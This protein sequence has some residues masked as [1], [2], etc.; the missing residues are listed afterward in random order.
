MNEINE[1]TWHIQD[2]GTEIDCSPLLPVKYVLGGRWYT[3][4]SR[5][6][7]T[8]NPIILTSDLVTDWNYE[9]IPNL[10]ETGIYNPESINKMR[11]MIFGQNAGRIAA[12]I[13]Y[14]T[15]A[16][17]NPSHQGFKFD[18]LLASPIM[19]HELIRL[20]KA[21]MK[22]ISIFSEI[23]SF[24]LGTYIIIVQVIKIKNK[25]FGVVIG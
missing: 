9:A 2:K 6:R 16:G 15:L 13:M 3:V 7:E 8:Y 22:G 4:D 21:I 14:R 23:S 20:L 11:N 17:Q 10:I 1:N 12:T 18:S 5:L 19:D 25:L 24:F